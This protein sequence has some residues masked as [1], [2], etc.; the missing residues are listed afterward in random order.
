M[1]VMKRKAPV[2]GDGDRGRDVDAGDDPE[3]VLWFIHS[4]LE[5]PC[6]FDRAHWFFHQVRISLRDSL[7]SQDV[8]TLDPV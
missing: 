2:A 6:K 4:Q 7:I 1:H 3:R 8:R 5:S